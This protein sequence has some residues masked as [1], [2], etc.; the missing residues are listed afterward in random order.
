MLP[1]TRPVMDIRFA[2]RRVNGR[3]SAGWE[4][5]KGIGQRQVNSR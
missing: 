3:M 1:I 2:G 5:V 4:K